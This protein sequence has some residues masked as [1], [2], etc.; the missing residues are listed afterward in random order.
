MFLLGLDGG[1]VVEDCVTS[2]EGDASE[3][4]DRFAIE[5]LNPKK[6]VGFIHGLEIEVGPKDAIAIEHQA[7]HT[8]S[9]FRGIGGLDRAG[10]DWLG[11]QA[12]DGSN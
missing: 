11:W 8:G 1:L 7:A 5:L 3:G 2:T 10:R 12:I 9:D 6:D 4:S